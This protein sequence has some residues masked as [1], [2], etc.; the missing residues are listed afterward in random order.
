[1]SVF[2]RTSEKSGETIEQGFRR[3]GRNKRFSGFVPEVER[4]EPSHIP[5]HQ[6]HLV[7]GF[8]KQDI[9]DDIAAHTAELIRVQME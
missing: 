6:I 7:Q 5:V 1:M 8:E 3:K 4:A 9:I 2:M